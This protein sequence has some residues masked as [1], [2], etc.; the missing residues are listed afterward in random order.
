M[1]SKDNPIRNKIFTIPAGAP[2]ARDLVAGIL[3]I[4]ADEADPLKLAAVTI[5]LPTRRAVRAVADAFLQQ[6]K[7][8]PLILPVLRPIGDVEEEALIFDQG[9]TSTL[10][11]DL[12][13]DL[14]PSISPLRRQLLL[15]RL[16]VAWSRAESKSGRDR[17]ALGLGPAA[18]L[19]AEL[20]TF[21]DLVE[22]EQADLSG[23][24]TLAPDAFAAHWQETVDF[25]QFVTEVWPKIL[26]DERVINPAARRSELI[27]AQALLWREKR[28]E[29]PIILAGS[30][31]S[32]PATVSLMQA[33]RSLPNGTLVLPGLDLD[34]DEKSWNAVRE[35][36]PQFG[37]KEL[38]RRLGADRSTV[39]TWSHGNALKTPALRREI[40]QEALRP[41]ETT[42]MW[43]KVLQKG[44][45]AADVKSAFESFSVIEAADPGEEARTIALVMRQTI[46]EPGQTAVLVTPDRNLARRVSGELRRWGLEV[47]D[48]AGTPLDR[49]PPGTFLKSVLRCWQHDFHPIDVLSLLKHPLCHL[50]RARP[51]L[52]AL[53]AQ[54]EVD[55][56]RGP[57][58][59][60]GLEGLR[61][62]AN[63]LKE[64][65][66]H[67]LL[68]DAL[69]DAFHPLEEISEQSSPGEVL[70]AALVRT[71]EAISCETSTEE[72]KLWRGGAGE[73]A[74]N[75]MSELLAEADAMPLLSLI[76]FSSLLDVLMAA[77]VVR[78]RYGTHPRLFIWG[79]LEARLQEADTIIL[80]GLNEKTW[81]AEANV[82]PWLS[83]PMRRALGLPSPERRIGLAAHDFAQL[84]SAPR[85][86]LTR[87]ERE[88]S[89]PTVPSRWLMRLQNMMKGLEAPECLAEQV[90]FLN[91]S[92]QMDKPDQLASAE[93]PRPKPPLSA[94]PRKMSVT[95]VERWIRDPYAIYAERILGLGILEPIDADATAM[96]RGIIVHNTLE[97][98]VRAYPKEL[99]K[100][101]HEKLIE[102]GR[103]EF[104]SVAPSPDVERFWWPRFLSVA[105]WFVEWERE[106]RS[107][108]LPLAVEAKATHTIKTKGGSFELTARADRIDKWK[109]D[110]SIGIYD[111][112]TGTAPTKRQVSAGLSPQLTLEALIAQ[113]GGFERVGKPSVTELAYIELKGGDPAGEVKL[114]DEDVQGLISAVR[115]GLQTLINLY[116]QEETPYLSR[117]RPMF[118]AYPGRYDHLAR[119]KEW[120]VYGS[121]D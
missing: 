82:D 1:N 40:I 115:E 71:A 16:I 94:R 46:E 74:A 118:D 72:Q 116:D 90:D 56:L 111:Y 67:T 117:L 96:E 121:K 80:G 57:R 102:M 107:E 61:Q 53:A 105:E 65:K 3:E 18:A 66:L 108:V 109:A 89:A 25:L 84:A 6:S 26:N 54:L 27:K 20:A 83:R 39:E 69:S 100:N 88:G 29:A 38:I 28:P 52:R 21:M 14:R 17:N 49:T 58:P 50:G 98:F 81:P 19:A 55:V 31:G 70:I 42:D 9:T 63:S 101:A 77:R 85:V 60:S 104:M 37:L 113:E 112:K 106:R 120:S 30:T 92:R 95:E 34:L 22:T 10:G 86:I 11:D 103:E 97:N 24:S 44:K 75:F 76:E 87:S 114:M 32:I 62:R 36:H 59:A 8:K 110:G 91:W 35:S 33:I 48:S 93:E 47:N 64:N 13:S 41:A 45:N 23:L 51:K 7:G 68:I 15:S 73:A 12:E 2:F 78:P 43:R 99:P 119:V 79:P 4:F 5:L